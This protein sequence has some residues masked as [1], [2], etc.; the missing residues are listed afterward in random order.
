VRSRS[1]GSFNTLA[2]GCGAQSILFAI[3]WIAGYIAFS[4]CIGSLFGKVLPWYANLVGG[5]ILGEVSIPAMIVCWILRLCG[6][7][8]PFFHLS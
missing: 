6:L 2:L 3:Y 8:V 1:L 5:L 4:Y 7:H